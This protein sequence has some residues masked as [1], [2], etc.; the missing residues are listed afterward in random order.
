[1][2]RF[3]KCV[4]VRG[5]GIFLQIIEKMKS[6]GRPQFQGEVYDTF[7]LNERGELLLGSKTIDDGEMDFASLEEEVM[8][9]SDED[10]IS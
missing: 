4:V 6:M 2:E 7:S 3:L 8:G 5:G 9:N 1:M 10:G